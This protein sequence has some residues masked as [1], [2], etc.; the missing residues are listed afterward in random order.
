MKSKLKDIARKSKMTMFLENKAILKE[1][2]SSVSF[3]ETD[4][5]FYSQYSA[6]NTLLHLHNQVI[7]PRSIPTLRKQF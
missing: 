7:Y 4:R 6:A 5:Q 3:V 1:V 2:L